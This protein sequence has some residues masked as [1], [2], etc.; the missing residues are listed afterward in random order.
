[1]NKEEIETHR[2]VQ[3][4]AKNQMSIR[5]QFAL[6]ALN[7]TLSDGQSEWSNAQM[8]AEFCY[9]VADAMMKE[10]SINNHLK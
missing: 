5:D 3:K 4:L 7:G 9:K 8:H 1:M 10:R 6:A 2:A